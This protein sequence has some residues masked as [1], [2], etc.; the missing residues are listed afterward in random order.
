[1]VDT[2]VVTVVDDGGV[3]GRCCGLYFVERVGP[4]Y[5]RGWKK[6]GR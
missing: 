6:A 5:R 2:G 1:M 3:I 4:Q